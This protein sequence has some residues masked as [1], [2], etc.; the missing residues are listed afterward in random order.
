M[1]II[2]F[3]SFA[4]ELTLLI[5][6]GNVNQGDSDFH[7]TTVQKYS[8]HYNENKM[9][10]QLQTVS[11]TATKTALRRQNRQASTSLFVTYQKYAL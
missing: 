1:D 10:M 3:K 9:R 2:A 7:K 4:A 5:K 6:S 8:I 11:R